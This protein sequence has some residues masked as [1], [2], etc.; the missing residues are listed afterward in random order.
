MPQ[1]QVH[2]RDSKLLPGLSQPPRERA[3]AHQQKLALEK[4]Q[5][6]V[7]HLPVLWCNGGAWQWMPAALLYQHLDQYEL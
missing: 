2:V 5:M 3:G 6:H 4:P 7:I 1:L